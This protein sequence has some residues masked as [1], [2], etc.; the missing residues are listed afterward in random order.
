M[1]LLTLP[2]MFVIANV[3]RFRELRLVATVSLGLDI[4]HECGMHGM[5]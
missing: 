5:L 4:S 2:D 1:R 3:V